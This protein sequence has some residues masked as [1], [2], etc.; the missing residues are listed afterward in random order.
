MN[1]QVY[2]TGNRKI[3]KIILEPSDKK[4]YTFHKIK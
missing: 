1:D 3:L 2:E 4:G